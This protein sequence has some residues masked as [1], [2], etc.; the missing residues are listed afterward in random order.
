MRTTQRGSARGWPSPRKRNVGDVARGL[1]G[2]EPFEILP[3]FSRPPVQ[4]ANGGIVTRLLERRTSD[5]VAGL[6]RANNCTLFMAAY[7]VLL[8][9]LHRYSGRTDIAVGTQVAGRE[10]IEFENLVGT[11]INTIA[12]RTDV[13]GDPAFLE[14]LERAR[15]TVTDALESRAVPL[16]QLVA[17]VNPKR[18]LSRS[19]LF[20]VNFVYQRSFIENAS[21]G[22]FKLVDLPSRSAGPICDLDFFMVERPEGWRVSCEFNADLYR[23]QTVDGML[24]RFVSLLDAVVIDPQRPIS[25]CPSSTRASASAC[26]RSAPERSRRTNARA[27]RPYSPSGL[28]RRRTPSRRSTRRLR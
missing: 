5:A 19:P 12:L 1:E 3:D 17:L 16:E 23:P 25:R 13:S 27:C 20:P 8:V 2:F 18:D 7:A 4:T 6:A 21:Y 28:R 24:Q 10:A 11:F 26:S 14:L 15:D 22:T 9:L